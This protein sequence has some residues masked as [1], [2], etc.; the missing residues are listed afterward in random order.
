VQ[1]RIRNKEKG[2]HPPCFFMEWNNISLAL[3]NG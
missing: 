3:L 2:L 1:I